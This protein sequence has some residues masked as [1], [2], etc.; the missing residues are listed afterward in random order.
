MLGD[1]ADLGL[2]ERLDL[3]ANA[4]GGVA[5]AKQE[6][7][8][9]HV[10]HLAPGIRSARCLCILLGP[11]GTRVIGRMRVAVVDPQKGGRAFPGAAP[12]GPELLCEQAMHVLVDRPGAHERRLFDV[13]VEALGETE[14]RREVAVGGDAHRA[15]ARG[16]ETLGNRAQRLGEQALV[17]RDGTVAVGIV[18]DRAGDDAVRCRLETREQGRHR[19]CGPRGWCVGTVEGDAL[20]R[21]R[22]EKRSRGWAA[23]GERHRVCAQGV[24]RDEYY[25]GRPVRRGFVAATAV[26][27]A[28]ADGRG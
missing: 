26:A 3:G 9:G 13:G 22:G 2:V 1:P 16:S 18:A 23:R 10:R 27:A 12:L 15:V 6:V 28:G 14:R 17:D 5:I 4:V 11:R 25:G 21:E 19:R 24:D 8:E 7:G 20:R